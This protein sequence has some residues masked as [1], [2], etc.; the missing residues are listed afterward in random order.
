MAA[1]NNPGLDAIQ[2]A[3]APSE[4]EICAGCYFFVTDEANNTVY[5]SKTYAEHLAAWDAIQNGRKP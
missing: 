5:Y 4:E 3:I 2:A 1:I